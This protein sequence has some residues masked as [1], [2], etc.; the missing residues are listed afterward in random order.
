MGL[1][2]LLVAMVACL[3]LEWPEAGEFASWSDS[4]RSWIAARMSS[5]RNATDASWG[6]SAEPVVAERAD[7][8]PVAAISGRLDLAFEAVV[9]G[10][11]TGFAGDLALSSPIT[12]VAELAEEADPEVAEEPTTAIPISLDVSP[13]RSERISAAVRLTR[14]AI[15]AWASLIEPTPSSADESPAD[16]Y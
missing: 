4:G 3:G 1:R 9:E 11:T 10:M 12:P 14:Q 13:L 2:I 7:E 16:S 8:A 15:G 6:W 5:L